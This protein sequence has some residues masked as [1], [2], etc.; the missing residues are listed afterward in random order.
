MRPRRLLL[1]LI[2][3][4]LSFSSV[5]G[6]VKGQATCFDIGNFTANSTFQ[7]ELD[8]L[9]DSIATT[10]S[11]TIN[12]GLFNVSTSPEI[13]TDAIESIG[14]CCGDQ[15]GDACRACL[16]VSA[17][18]IRQQCPLR[19][20]AAIFEENC[21]L[22]Y[23]NGSLYG[24]W[25]TSLTPY[26]LWNPANASNW[27]TFATAL[28]QLLD[29]LRG[30]ASS[31]GPVRKYASGT[32]SVE[33]NTLFATVQCSPD[34]S[35]QQ[36]SDCLV[37]LTGMLQSGQVSGKVGARLLWPSCQLRYET[38]RFFD[39]TISLP[40]PPLPPATAVI[41]PT[42]TP[43]DEEDDDVVMVESLQFNLDIISEATDN[44]SN[45][46]K[47]G[48]GG[49]GSVYL[50][51]LPNGQ[52]I[53]VKRL[54]RNSGQGQIEFKN[55]VVLLARLQHRNLVRLLGFC[56]EGN[57]RVLVYEFVPNSSLDQ[58]I[59]DQLKRARLDWDSRYKII[60]GIA[61]GLLYLHEDSRL[62]I[63]HRD[64]KASN[65]LLDADMNPKV[66]DFGMA[67]LFELDQTQADTN[68]IVGTYGY[69]APEYVLHGHFSVKSDVF[70]FGVLMLEIV[71]GR[72]NLDSHS[73][74]GGDP[75]ILI[76]HVWRSWRE[77][78]I[79]NILDPSVTSG[80]SPD[81]L[82]CIHIGL[83]CVQE[84]EASRPTMA[85]VIVML[86][87]HSVSLPIPTQPAFSTSM[88]YTSDISTSVYGTSTA[89]HGN[90]SG[91]RT[92]AGRGSNSVN[93]ISITMPY[94]R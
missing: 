60:T 11:T 94:P 86:N 39:P 38:Y 71:S 26:M 42:S 35:D 1:L 84:N 16:N 27:D 21:T 41:P 13:N 79:G 47:L 36:C 46:K 34:L 2:V 44:F 22:K 92:G 82:R 23:S 45:A 30:Q 88:I 68:R 83:L 67:R 20:K 33:L 90:T 62:R 81:I 52:Q 61:R 57:E 24:V 56:L 5:S 31:G 54:S 72:K 89:S 3:V 78:K 65:I 93:E 77:G 7:T 28:K 76:S 32:G 9:L 80:Y 18:Q 91:D 51:K 85:S 66:S 87:S 55:E 49:F 4:V 15:D 10:T 12:Y 6:I 53:A 19:K 37:Q 73:H 64:L 69:M 59:F 75:E 29:D 8:S 25:D 74:F 70:S 63:I 58:F 48:Q 14:Y 50:G 40:S 17:Y 43:P